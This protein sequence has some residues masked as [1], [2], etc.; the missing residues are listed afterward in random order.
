MG[1]IPIENDETKHIAR[2]AVIVASIRSGGT[3]LA[4]CLSN[5]PQ[6][7]CD[8]GESLHHTSLW[9]SHLTT[10]RAK[11][12]FCLTHMHGYQVSMVKLLYQQAFLV[13]VWDYIRELPIIWLRR[14]NT[15]R[16]AVSV[17]LNKMARRGRIEHPQHTFG[18]VDPVRVELEPQ[19]VLN[20]ARNLLVHDRRAKE[21][22]DLLNTLELI[23]EEIVGPGS[24]LADGVARRI[25]EFLG[26]RSPRCPLSCDLTRINPRPLEEMIRNWDEVRAAIEASEFAACLAMQNGE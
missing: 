8:R 9:H 1:T 20:A 2:P 13:E 3:F 18:K 7:F 5:H 26:V 24:T 14:E 17:I 15:I 10:N 25:C 22:L 4:H 12:L 6:I 19:R 11:V 23:Y 16:Q 21:L